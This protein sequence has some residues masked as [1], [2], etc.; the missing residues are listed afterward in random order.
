MSCSDSKYYV[1]TDNDIL[2]PKTTPDWLTQMVTLM[3]SNNEVAFLTPQLPP[4]GLQMPY[5]KDSDLVYL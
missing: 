1:V 2:P 3:E 4:Q 5:T